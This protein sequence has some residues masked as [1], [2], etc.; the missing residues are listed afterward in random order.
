MKKI[1]QKFSHTLSDAVRMIRSE[2]MHCSLFCKIHSGTPSQSHSD[3]DIPATALPLI[4]QTAAID[5]CRKS[6]AHMCVETSAH[7]THK[8]VRA[9]G[10]C[11]EVE[12]VYHETAI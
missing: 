8:E 11:L 5:P 9:A 10:R 3:V 6:P 4:Q 7:M 1:E 2:Y 12:A